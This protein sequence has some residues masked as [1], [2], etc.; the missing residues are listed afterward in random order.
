MSQ[1]KAIL[2]F[3]PA[4]ELWVY[5]ET[6]SDNRYQCTELYNSYCRAME[7]ITDWVD[8][9]L[10]SECELYSENDG[11]MGRVNAGNLFIWSERK[12]RFR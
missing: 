12:R 1:N 2:N 4:R 6:T 9:G 10:I 7:D 8:R 5:T 11:W 3:D